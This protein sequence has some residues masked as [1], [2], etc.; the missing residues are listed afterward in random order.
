MQRHLDLHRGY[1]NVDEIDAGSFFCDLCGLMFRQH[2]NLIK[3]W[4][5]ACPEI[6]ANIP[7]GSE[8]FDD[9]S[10]KLFVSELLQSVVVVRK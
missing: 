3:H 7:Q 8:E 1:E 5:T 2:S 6:Q 9:Q 4:R 10:L